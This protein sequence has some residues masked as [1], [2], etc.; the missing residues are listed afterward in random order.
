MARSIRMYVDF[1]FPV[2]FWLIW[3][4]LLICMCTGNF[5]ASSN[6]IFQKEIILIAFLLPTSIHTQSLCVFYIIKCPSIFL[7]HT[8]YDKPTSSNAFLSFLSSA[9]DWTQ[10][11]MN[12][13]Q[14][15]AHLRNCWMFCNGYMV[16]C[17]MS[18]D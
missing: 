6:I 10:V 13:R 11:L 2:S 14:V 5:Q 18:T 15:Y 7:A 3:L 4:S 1:A 9:K 8:M 16:F 17:S 12:A